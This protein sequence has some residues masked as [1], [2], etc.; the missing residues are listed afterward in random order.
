MFKKIIVFYVVTMLCASIAYGTEIKY[1]FDRNT[2]FPTS[3]YAAPV[4][5]RTS[6]VSRR[7]ASRVSGAVRAF[8]SK[9]PSGVVDHNLKEIYVFGELQFYGKEF[10]ATYSA[11]KIYIRYNDTRFGD[12]PAL[13][14][15]QMHHEFSSV[16]MSKHHFPKSEWVS[17][18]KGV[19]VSKDKGRDMLST[20]GRDEHTYLFKKGFLTSY[21]QADF[22][23]D[24]N[25][26]AEYVFVFPNKL[27][28]L[29]KKYSA[30]AAKTKIIRN[31]YC[32]ISKGFSFC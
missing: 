21:G 12:W 11:E 27:D 13:A 1:K 30:V 16:L 6:A 20:L 14:A 18:N 19:Y 32:G 26:Y 5:A 25:I 9:Y 4:R 22:E 10:G 8:L 28:R 24:V 7:G 29:G 31:F 23:N 17:K 2:C 15:R 3:W